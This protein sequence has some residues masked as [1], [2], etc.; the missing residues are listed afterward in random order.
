MKKNT[1]LKLGFGVLLSASIVSCEN[2]TSNEQE[3]NSQLIPEKII[4]LD[5]AIAEYN[6]FYHT[7]IAP[8]EG[9]ANTNQ[10]RAVWFDMKSLESHLNKINVVANQNNIAVTGISISLL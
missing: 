4:S 1:F 2:E 5:K 8:F 3:L 6:N 9:K 10:T 7:R